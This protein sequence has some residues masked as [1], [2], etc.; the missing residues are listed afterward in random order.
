MPGGDLSIP[1]QR[2]G[3]LLIAHIE[4]DSTHT[5]KALFG[6]NFPWPAISRGAMDELIQLELAPPV[7]QNQYLL[8]NLSIRGRP[9]PD[10]S[11]RVTSALTRFGVDLVLGV[12][13]LAQ[14]T[15]LHFYWRTLTLDLVTP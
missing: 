12:D 7:Q 9:F 10:L 4:V 15:E 3:N 11:V 5:L 14:Y 1:S 13:F 6:P 2:S 8:R